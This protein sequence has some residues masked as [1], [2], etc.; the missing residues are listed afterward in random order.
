MTYTDA[1]ALLREFVSIRSVSTD[2]TKADDMRAAVKFLEYHLVRLGFEVKQLNQKNHP[3]ILVAKRIVTPGGTTI[4]IYGHY[5]VQP[6][7]P[8][9]EWK[10]PPYTLTKKHGKFFGRG[11]AD[12]KGHIIQNL[13]AIENL[14]RKNQLHSN[15]VCI[16]EG[17][18]EMGESANFELCLKIAKKALAG[19]D[20]FMVTD[21]GMYAKGVPQIYFGLR[22]MVY[23]EIKLETG[24]TDL[25]SGQYGNR[26]LNPIQ[27][28]NALF[29]EMKDKQGR[30]LIPG[31]Y[32]SVRRP[33]KLEFELLKKVKRT[34][35]QD[36]KEARAYALAPFFSI[37]PDLSTKIFPS[38]DV[39][40]IYSGYVGPG[41]KTVIPRQ[42]MAKFSLRLVENQNPQIVAGLVTKFVEQHM[43]KGV[44]YE[45]KMHEMCPAFYTDI[46]HPIMQKIA[47][48]LTTTFKHET[49]YNRAGGS[50]PAAEILQRLFKKP[51]ILTG[52]TL[53][54]ENIHAPNENFDEDM[55]YKG[56]TALEH[57]YA[58]L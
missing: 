18:E 46:T 10:T 21:V 40:G 38:L 32:D 9:K 24:A 4:G 53:P 27:L 8:V 15:I 5:D 37:H 2:P 19:I 6:E 54:D 29:A 36:M 30:I 57:I 44:R 41:A 49:L 51:V 26:A 16:F 45:L 33:T 43:P 48:I 22:G 14:I 17:E 55:F 47:Q 25:H 39:H 31:F 56:I 42:A 34:D 28:L 11:V 50:V 58:G 3:P 23:F 13:A 20:L 1:A 7:D 12:N 35:L 52:F